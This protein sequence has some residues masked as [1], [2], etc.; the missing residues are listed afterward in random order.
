MKVGSSAK[1]TFV[2]QRFRWISTM[3]LSP[4]VSRS[5]GDSHP[6]DDAQEHNATGHGEAMVQSDPTRLRNVF[7]EQTPRTQCIVRALNARKEVLKLHDL[8]AAVPPTVA[9]HPLLLHLRCAAI[10]LFIEDSLS[11]SVTLRRGNE[12]YNQHRQR[13][14]SACKAYIYQAVLNVNKRRYR[15]SS[16]QRPTL[17]NPTSFSEFWDAILTNQISEIDRANIARYEDAVVNAQR[18]RTAAIT[19]KVIKLGVCIAQAWRRSRQ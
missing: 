13:V 16:T 4:T 15:M 11:G 5:G 3:S 8:P 2:L 1:R 18:Q 14:R 12:S 9:L 19:P 10:D 17:A 7:A 6:A